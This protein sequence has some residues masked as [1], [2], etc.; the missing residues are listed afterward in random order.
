MKNSEQSQSIELL[1]KA[2]ELTRIGRTIR[3]DSCQ[4]V[5]PMEYDECPRCCRNRSFQ[6]VQVEFEF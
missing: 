3:C 4:A 1:A 5:F 2:E 6:N